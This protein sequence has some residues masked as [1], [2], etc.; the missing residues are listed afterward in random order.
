MFFERAL[1][2]KEEQVVL[3]VGTW[4]H[5]AA[6]FTSDNDARLYVNGALVEVIEGTSRANRSTAP[7]YIGRQSS[8]NKA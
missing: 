4:T 2:M 6:V 3:T 1:K 8:I 5:V 7:L